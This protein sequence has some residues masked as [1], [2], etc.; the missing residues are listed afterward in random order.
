M[1]DWNTI[2]SNALKFSK[3]Y[4]KSTNENAEKQLFYIDFFEIFGI[5]K[6]EFHNIINFEYPVT[7]ISKTT[8]FIDVLWKGVILIEHKSVG[9]DLNKA[10]FRQVEIFFMFPL[11]IAI[12]HSIFGIMFSNYI[13]KASGVSFDLNSIIMTAVF[14]VIIYGGYFVVTY[15]SSK[16]IIREKN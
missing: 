1:L 11:L 7:S 12:I 16:N 2:K 3:K 15:F 6:D 4:E 8:K 5:N 14:I 10:L 9:K 13:L